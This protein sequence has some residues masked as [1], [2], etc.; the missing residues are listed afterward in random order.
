MLERTGKFEVAVSTNSLVG[1]N[2]AKE[3]LPD[4]IILDINMAQMD[5]GEVAQILRQNKTT[6]N[7][8][9]IFLTALLKKEETEATAGKIG[10]CSYIAKPAT[11]Q[12]LIEKIEIALNNSDEKRK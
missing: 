6:S 4:L 8:P 1:I 9:I 5:G 3:E 2:R 11:P 7:I 10:T 12:E